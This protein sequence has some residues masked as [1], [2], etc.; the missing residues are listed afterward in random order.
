MTEESKTLEQKFQE[1]VDRVRNGKVDKGAKEPSDNVKLKFYGL[2]KQATV[3]DCNIA[4]P[5]AVNIA[6]RAKWEAWNANKGMTLDEAKQAYVD[7]LAA[8]ETF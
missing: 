8:S 5:W 6:A 2:Y 1:A 3:G 7:L 4:Q